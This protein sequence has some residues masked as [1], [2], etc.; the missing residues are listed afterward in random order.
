MSETSLTFV[1][2]VLS[3]NVRFTYVYSVCF[4][5]CPIIFSRYKRSARDADCSRPTI[6]T[7][8]R[9]ASEDEEKYLTTELCPCVSGRQFIAI[10]VKSQLH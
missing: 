4:L 6:T 8:F 10:S 2:D 3:C 5:T 1:L 9:S 7:L